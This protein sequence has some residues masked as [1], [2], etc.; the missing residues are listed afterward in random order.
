MAQNCV[1]IS[2]EAVLDLEKNIES[3][4]KG[5]SSY[6]SSLFK[7]M[8]FKNPKNAKILYEFLITEQNYQN[9]KLSTKITHIKAI[10][11]FN[12]YINYKDFEKITKNDIMDYLN[13]LRKT[14][15]DDP[16]HKWIGTYNTRQMAINKFFRW[17]YNQYQ[18]NVMD[19]KRWIT[20]PC[21]QGVKQLSR[22]ETSPYKPSDLWTN[23]DH[24]LFLKYCPEKRA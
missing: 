15:S 2:N 3:I 11:L 21:M 4:C 1:N 9:V 12:Q 8:S 23:E 5:A 7:K 22:K 6:Y 16:N 10:C 20:S 14:E 13:S 19:Q 24:V 18:N 17:L